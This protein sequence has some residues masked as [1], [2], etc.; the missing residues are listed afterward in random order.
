MGKSDKNDRNGDSQG[1]STKGKL[2]DDL[3]ALFKLPL[4]EFT[5]ARNTLA[6]QLKK[7]GRADEAER[8]KALVKPP[9]SAWTVNQLYWLHRD[10]FDQL[11]DSGARFHKAQ[12][13]LSAGKLANMRGALDARRDALTHLADLATSLLRDAGHNP[14]PDTIHRITTTLEAISAYASRSDGPRNGRLIHD[15][16]PPGFE[17]LGSFVPDAGTTKSSAKPLRLVTQSQRIQN[18]QTADTRRKAEPDAH[19]HRLEDMHKARI[20][21]AKASLQA[22]KRSLTEARATAQSLDAT[23][24]KANAEMKKAEKHRHD[25]EE[26]LQKA[27]TAFEDATRRTRSVAVEVEEAARSVKYAERTVEKA[28]EELERLVGG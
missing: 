6:A 28:A 18:S 24:Q 8:V 2:E 25:A 10:A 23:H 27:K 17:T 3:D 13:S 26:S 14:A 16:D 5:A 7:A 20:A 15:I 11:I 9:I 21:E 4:T 1:S 19:A 22:A 12:S